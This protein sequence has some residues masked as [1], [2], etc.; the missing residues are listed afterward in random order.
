MIKRIT[1]SVALI[2]SVF[3]GYSQSD[4]NSVDKPKWT[5]RL[6]I[7]GNVALQFGTFTLI[8][9]NPQLGYRFTDRIV[10]GAGYSYF[11]S[12]FRSGGVKFADRIHGPTA[13]SRV[14]VNENIFARADY[15]RLT[16]TQVNGIEGLDNTVFRPAD[17]L[18][19]GGGYRQ[20]ISSRMFATAAVFID[21]LDPNPQPF[22]RA[23]I[24]A[25]LG[26]W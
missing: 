13:F 9:G 24:E 25:G 16:Y 1:L 15:Q 18:F 19:L 3:I 7:D 23:G 14:L 4:E 17:R 6:V 10:A 22:F 20:P 11:Y 21:V 2:F 12:S 5:D 8:G 26:R